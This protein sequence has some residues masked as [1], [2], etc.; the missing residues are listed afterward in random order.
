M[1]PGGGGRP[2]SESGKGE[3]GRERLGR[4]KKADQKEHDE[5]DIEASSAGENALLQQRVEAR[6]IPQHIT[7][8]LWLQGP[9]SLT[10]K[11]VP[12]Y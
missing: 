8:R 4:R 12:A 5:V 10:F 11:S 9:K 6:F 1:K 3:S 7:F 2:G